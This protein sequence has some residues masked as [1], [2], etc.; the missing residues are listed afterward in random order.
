[1]YWLAAELP[2]G[3]ALSAVAAGGKVADSKESRHQSQP[4]SKRVHTSFYVAGLN[5]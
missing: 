5:Y 2:G 3:T 1:V 4:E